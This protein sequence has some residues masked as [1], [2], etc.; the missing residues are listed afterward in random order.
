[1]KEIFPEISFHKEFKDFER[2]PF[3]RALRYLKGDE[4]SFEAEYR[5]NEAS[6]ILKYKQLVIFSNL[7]KKH[8]ITKFVPVKGMY[9]LNTLFK[10]HYGL[11]S[12]V[13]IDLLF[14]P[15]E[16]AQIPE[17]VK[18]SPQLKLKKQ[19]HPLLRRYFCEDIPVLLNGTLIELHSKMSFISFGNFIENVFENSV[20]K[21]IDNDLKMLLPEIEQMALIMLIHDHMGKNFYNLVAGRLL[22][23]YVVIYNCDLSKLRKTADKFGLGKMLD[24]HLF[25][26]YTMI[27]EPF[28]K[29]S[30]FDIDEAFQ[31]IDRDEKS[32]AFKV[33]KE[34]SL[35]MA[36][37]GYKTI[38]LRSRIISG[39]LFRY[40]F[41]GKNNRA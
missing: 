11:R 8:K 18:N 10:D 29:K 25:L 21:K 34:F 27:E 40:M 16:F 12:M 14:H 2:D 17:L 20:E 30:D 39:T 4:P 35:Q 36:L 3:F 22:E 5:A 7:L 37:F 41:G 6:N 33:E 19:F 38:L 28:F 9:L 24:C 32:C 1:M 15:E 31:Y 13:D 26:I 23:F